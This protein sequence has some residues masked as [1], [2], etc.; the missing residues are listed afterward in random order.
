[1][2]L[3]T[4]TLATLTVAAAAGMLPLP[5]VASS[6]FAQT[7]AAS[8]TSANALPDAD[9]QFVQTASAAGSTEIDAAKLA[10]HQ[11]NDADVKSF[12]RHMIVDH[13]K[14]AA[15]LKMAAPHGVSIPKDNADQQ[16]LDALKPLKGKDFDTAYVQKLAVQG[17]K[18][19]VAVFQDEASNGQNASLKK[20]A[21][22]A[23]PTIQHHYKMAQ[24]L[25]Q[26]KGIAAQ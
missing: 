19:A 4:T 18:D 14:L 13:T 21:Q 5:F 25:A 7:D 10:L 20:A 22:K 15:Q 17:H 9:R 1:M 23:L 6:A 11:S 16:A 12:A 24:A 3:A 26:K 8:T 2:K